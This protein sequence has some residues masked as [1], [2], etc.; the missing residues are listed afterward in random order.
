MIILLSLFEQ[1]IMSYVPCIQTESQPQQSTSSTSMAASSN[2]SGST[3][4]SCSSQGISS[5]IPS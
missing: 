1:E 5:P 4:A 2:T 3:Q